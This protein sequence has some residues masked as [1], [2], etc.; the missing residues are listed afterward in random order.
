[1][2]TRKSET[3]YSGP[4]SVAFWRRIGKLPEGSRDAAYAMGCILQDVEGR[5]LAFL[6]EAAQK[7]NKP[8]GD[9]VEAE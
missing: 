8:R 3:H 2:K 1:M 9:R 4:R 6:R 5:V 7:E